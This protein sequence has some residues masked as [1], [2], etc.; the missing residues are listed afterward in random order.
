MKLFPPGSTLWLLAHELKLAMRQRRR[1]NRGGWIFLLILMAGA[2]AGGVGIAFLLRD[3]AP[4]IT[5]N[6]I[7]VALGD[8]ALVLVGTLMLSNTLGATALAFYERGDLDLLL[9]S[10]VPPR[11][12]LAVR[13]FGIALTPLLFFTLILV[14]FL[15]PI[16]VI[17]NHLPWLATFAVLAALSLTAS[18]L[19]LVIALALFAIIGPRRTR[20]VSQLLAALIGAAFFLA[21]Q[22]ARFAGSRT[23]S[24]FGAWTY[25]ERW[26]KEGRFEPDSPASW[27][28]RA[29]MGDPL[30]AGVAVAF[31]V[32]LFWLVT[33]SL[34]KRFAANAAAAAGSQ[35]SRRRKPDLSKV[36][37]FT[38]NAFQ[39]MVTK[40]TRLLLRDPVLLSQVLLR[41]LYLLPAAF[42]LW[43]LAHRGG[44]DWALAPGAAF[45][46]FAAGQTAGSLAWI[47][48]SAED[49]PELLMCSPAPRGT[50]R[51]AKLVAAL[52]P[53]FFILV[54]PLVGLG[55]FSPWAAAVAAVGCLCASVSSGLICLWYERPSKRTDFRRRRTA[56]LPAA[57]GESVVQLC[58][59][60]AT[61][62]FVAKLFLFAPI[63]AVLAL[64]ILLIMRRPDAMPAPVK[65]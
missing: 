21:S 24:R 9:S 2:A 50:L 16:A 34:G 32:L 12:V 42:G 38:G 18:A 49:A 52:R 48:I 5:L 11:R 15:V 30:Y 20:T 59:G 10:P 14:P 51:R 56:S 3:K 27:P 46:V 54:V 17:A 37:G 62:L 13:C 6:P 28:V 35:G 31:A 26:I 39:A 1:G 53:V 22:S 55:W 63:P 44:S 57:I 60:G 45:I 25:V 58:W 36:K 19:G 33:Q 41:I 47:T 4:D 64:V 23:Y 65:A 7:M 40:E 43:Q 8:L 61:A 29:M